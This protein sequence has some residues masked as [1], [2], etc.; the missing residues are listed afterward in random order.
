MLARGHHSLSTYAFT[1]AWEHAGRRLEALQ[2]SLDPATQ[3]RLLGVGVGPGWQCLELG[4]GRGSI[5]R[6]LAEQVGPSGRVVATDIDTRF[7]ESLAGSNL[8]VRR[9]D[10]L[11]DDLP[12]GAFDL[13]HT[14]LLLM[15]L[16][17]REEILPRLASALKPGGRLLLEEHDAFPIRALAA[18][19]YRNVWEAFLPVLAAAGTN[20][21]WARDL[22]GRL[23][24][25]GYV[26]VS[27][28]VQVPMFPGG[29]P[30]S[31]F[32]SITFDQVRDRIIAAGAQPQD[33]E[34]AIA[35]LTKPA[36]WFVASAMVAVSGRRP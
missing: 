35:E 17:A 28:E 19:A 11:R 31:E 5:A 12:A 9:H 34:Q 3:R 20:S 25:L 7:L 10:L 36:C 32:W 13:I 1:N 4:A 22:P 16:P 23:Q 8:E 26:H 33:L 27:A 6:W 14:R 24:E 18:G 15:H 30:A 29:S 21:F 2:E